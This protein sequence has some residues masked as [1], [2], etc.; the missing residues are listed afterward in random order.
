MLTP[1]RPAQ[2]GPLPEVVPA[3]LAWQ[4]PD[5]GRIA[6]LLNRNARRVTD[7]VAHSLERVVGSDHVY[8]SRTLDEA[9]AFT[10]EIVQ[11]GYGTVVCGGGDGTLMRAV[12]LVHRYIAESNNWRIERYHRTG[13]KQALLKSP[14]FA[15]LR[16]GTGNG[17]QFVTG[18]SNPARDLQSIVDFV[19]GRTQ[20][21]PLIDLDGER[22]FF[23]GIGY[24][25]QILDDYNWIKARA[26]NRLFKFFMQN[27]TGYLIALFAR[28]VPR[29][30]LGRSE[31]IEARVVNRGRAYYVNPLRGDF[32]EEI[33]PGETIF[34]GKCR[35]ISGGTVPF[36]GYGFKMFPFARL[37]PGMMNL[38]IGTPGPL[39]VLHKIPALWNGSYRLPGSLM[40]FL[41]EDVTIEL[42]KP[43][44]FQHSGDAQGLR[45]KLDL[46]IADD[47][48]EFVDLHRP[49]R[50]S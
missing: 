50:T 45:D 9:E 13:E 27:V 25:S 39:R 3:E 33:P 8:N 1:V 30:L 42:A 47:N 24:D 5:A 34:E 21:I 18:A 7:R 20:E 2:T 23:G 40:D 14:R 22:F 15:F 49:R 17:M 31:K 12:N 10:R 6:V 37:M 35:I 44:P 19:P 32:V 16:L 26:K 29:L 38:R 41:V 11:R 46:R 43:F 4:K 36:F 48:L 28:T